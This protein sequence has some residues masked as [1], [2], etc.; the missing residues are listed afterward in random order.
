MEKSGLFEPKVINDYE[1]TIENQW[2]MVIEIFYKQYERGMCCIK[3]EGENKDYE[4]MTALREINRGGAPQPQPE[5]DMATR[6]YI[7]AMEERSTMQDAHIKDLM[8]RGPPTT[9]PATDGAAAA[10]VI[11]RGSNRSSTKHQALMS[12]RTLLSRL[13]IVYQIIEEGV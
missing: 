6:E 8:E 10:S 7:A 12:K 1:N 9:I 13:S 11:T 2:T 3:R 4:I 5:A